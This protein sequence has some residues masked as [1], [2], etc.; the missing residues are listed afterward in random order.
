MT[1]SIPK[2]R[3][4]T[5]VTTI[6]QQIKWSSDISAAPKGE[7][8]VNKRTVLLKGKPVDQEIPTFIPTFIL[9][10]TKCGKVVRTCWLPIQ[11]TASGAKLG[12]ERWD[13]FNPGSEPLLWAHWPDA[14]ELGATLAAANAADAVLAYAEEDA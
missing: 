1:L 9:A 14:T 8:V 11:R 13:G 5:P 10:L 7:T 3:E 12:G 6:Y 4:E 2:S